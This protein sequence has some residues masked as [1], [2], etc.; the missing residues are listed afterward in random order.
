MQRISRLILAA[1]L[2][3]ATRAPGALAAMRSESRFDRTQAV[4]VRGPSNGAAGADRTSMRSDRKSEDDG[5]R[6]Y[7]GERRHLQLSIAPASS[8]AKAT[9]RS[10]S[11]YRDVDCRRPLEIVDRMAASEASARTRC[12]VRYD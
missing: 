3:L 6:F 4:T 2:L 12:D 9:Q 1:L 11:K 8:N 5:D 10:R 7:E